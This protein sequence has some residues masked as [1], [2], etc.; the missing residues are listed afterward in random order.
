MGLKDIA[1]SLGDCFFAQ[2]V[3]VW[4]VVYILGEL[5]NF[6]FY[7]HFIK[8]NPE[9]HKWSLSHVH[10]MILNFAQETVF[11]NTSTLR[12]RSHSWTIPSLLLRF[13]Q[14][15]CRYAQSIDAHLVL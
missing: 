3:Y 2:L 8:M 10:K 7:P 11:L 4:L 9:F 5:G 15:V 1:F 6:D 14:P 13:S 12:P